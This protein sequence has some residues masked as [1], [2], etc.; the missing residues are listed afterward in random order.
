MKKRLALIAC[1]TLVCSTAVS[2]QQPLDDAA[3]AA[4]IRAGETKKYDHLISDCIATAG[5]GANMSASIAG[6]IQPV[7]GFTVIVSRA[8]GR[9]AFMAADGK[10]LYQPLMVAAVPA[11]MRESATVYV[12]AVPQAPNASKTSYDVASPIER[13]VLKAK[14]GAAVAQPENVD[15]TPVEWKNLLG[16]TIQGNSAVA[17]FKVGDVKELPAG[18]VDIVLITQAGERRCKIGG[19]DRLKLFGDSGGTK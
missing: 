6:G 11:V 10:R 16:G 3:V 2:G 18:D 7:G 14:G 19:K 15:L 8:P 12:T 13:I 5:F 4:A 1:V 9:I 17:T